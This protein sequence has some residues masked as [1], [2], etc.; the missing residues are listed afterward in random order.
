M[1]VKDAAIYEM[2]LATHAVIIVVIN[3]IFDVN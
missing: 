3:A 2:G 1:R